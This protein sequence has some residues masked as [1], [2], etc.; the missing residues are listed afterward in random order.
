MYVDIVVGGGG[1]V[2]V[3]T[4]NRSFYPTTSSAIQAV[5]V[6]ILHPREIQILWSDCEIEKKHMMCDMIHKYTMYNT[7][8]DMI[9][10][11]RI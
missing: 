11:D 6:L 5:S 2:V 7:W 3:F 10:Y 4:L 1:G 8:Y 9:G